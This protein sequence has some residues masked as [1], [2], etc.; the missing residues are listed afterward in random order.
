MSSG[1]KRLRNRNDPDFKREKQE[2]SARR[3]F[4]EAQ[5]KLRSRL[6]GFPLREDPFDWLGSDFGDEEG[7]HQHTRRL[8]SS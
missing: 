5:T 7:T 8:F 1:E 2:R 3:Q 4:K 6:G